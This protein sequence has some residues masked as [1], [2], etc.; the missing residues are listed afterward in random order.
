MQLST[1]LLSLDYVDYQVGC[2][3]FMVP[4]V[5]HSQYDE[6]FGRGVFGLLKRDNIA[7]AG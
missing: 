4:D 3:G 5:L 2:C 1:G 6:S 7:S